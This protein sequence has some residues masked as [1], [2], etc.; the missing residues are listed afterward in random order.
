MPSNKT[1]KD[2]TSCRVT[3]EVALSG[4]CCQL[5]SSE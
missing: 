3:R 4:Y 2:P 1:K 5:L